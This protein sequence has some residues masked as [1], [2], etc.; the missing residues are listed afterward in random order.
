MG[1]DAVL[2]TLVALLEKAQAIFLGFD[3]AN[4]GTGEAG[5]GD[6]HDCPCPR[7]FMQAFVEPRVKVTWKGSGAVMLFGRERQPKTLTPRSECQQSQVG[8]TDVQSRRWPF[9]S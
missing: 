7:L 8:I 6:R 3:V 2:Q 5:W 1:L 4:A 9:Q